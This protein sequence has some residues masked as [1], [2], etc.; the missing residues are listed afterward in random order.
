ML[1]YKLP[2]DNQITPVTLLSLEINKE[3]KENKKSVMDI[4]CSDAEGVQV[5]IEIWLAN[6]HDM[7]RRT[8]VR[9]EY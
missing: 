4:P 1:P 2:Q 9:A 5:S 6:K 3:Y 8:K 7:E